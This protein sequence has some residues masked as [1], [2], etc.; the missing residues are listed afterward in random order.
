MGIQDNVVMLGLWI[1]ILQICHPLHYS[2]LQTLH[3][4]D[5]YIVILADSYMHSGCVYEY[6]NV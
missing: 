4:N 6:M 5:L 1:I 3:L 2:H